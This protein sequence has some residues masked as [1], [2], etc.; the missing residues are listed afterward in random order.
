MRKLTYFSL[1]LAIYMFG[2]SSVD[3]IIVGM[4]SEDQVRGNVA[5]FDNYLANKGK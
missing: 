1:V 2:L 4:T 3:A 5:T